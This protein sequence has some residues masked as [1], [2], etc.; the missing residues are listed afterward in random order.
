[1]DVQADRR[2]RVVVG[3]ADGC[4][5]PCVEGPLNTLDAL[6]SVARQKGG[7]G[8]FSAF[9]PTPGPPAEPLAQAAFET[10]TVHLSWSEPAEGGAPVKLYRIYRTQTGSPEELLSTVPNTTLSF[11][12]GA[13]DPAKNP[14]YEVRAANVYGESAAPSGC[15]NRIAPA[16]TP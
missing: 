3:F 11:F 16:G 4:T 2:G 6:A 10:G 13:Y 15:D 9:D 12:D 1:M 8:L 5:G 14:R 7:L